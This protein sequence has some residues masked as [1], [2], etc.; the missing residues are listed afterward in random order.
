[1]AFLAMGTY[2]AY[3]T[4]SVSKLKKDYNNPATY[5]DLM[6]GIRDDL[7][8]H[9]VQNK[10][11]IVDFCLYDNPNEFFKTIPRSLK[12]LGHIIDKLYFTL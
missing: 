8:D 6:S 11:S 5:H 1:M 2:V 9:L 12:P 7:I 10:I 3:D 4:T